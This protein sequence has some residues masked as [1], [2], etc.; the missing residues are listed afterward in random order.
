MSNGM[1]GIDTGLADSFVGKLNAGHGEIESV[2]SSTR[3]KVQA[4]LAEW[5][6]N[7]K[8]TFTGDWEPWEADVRKL[9]DL[10]TEISERLRRTTEAF[11]SADHF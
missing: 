6:G 9:M 8:N 10:I 3:A 11:R 4:L 7:S 2:L 1:I 5:Q